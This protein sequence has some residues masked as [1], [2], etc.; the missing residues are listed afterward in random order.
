M[1]RSQQY[2]SLMP[3]TAL[4]TLS[5]DSILY[6]MSRLESRH[7]QWPGACSAGISME[8]APTLEGT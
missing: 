1:T 4:H 7:K 2:L 5:T 6:Q 8:D 3:K